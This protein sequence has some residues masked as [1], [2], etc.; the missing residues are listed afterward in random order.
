MLN[1]QG[2][3]RQ[4]PSSRGRDS[5]QLTIVSYCDAP[6]RMFADRSLLSNFPLAATDGMLRKR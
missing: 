4:G 3:L 2:D 6:R 5:V 1:S